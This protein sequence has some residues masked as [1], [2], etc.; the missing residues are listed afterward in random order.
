MD[1]VKMQDAAK[2]ASEVMKLLGHSDRLMI[3]CELKAG[4]QSVGQLT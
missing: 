4:E 3:L 1:L 2:K